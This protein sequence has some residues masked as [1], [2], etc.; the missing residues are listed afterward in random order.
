MSETAIAIAS[1]LALIIVNV[2]VGLRQPHV[3][4]KAVSA[5][6]GSQLTNDKGESLST[7][8]ENTI[9]NKFDTLS[10]TFDSA[11]QTIQT[12]PSIA[13][14]YQTILTFQQEQLRQ[15]DLEIN[16]FRKEI[17]AMKADV[18]SRANERKELK[19]TVEDL[20][21]LTKQQAADTQSQLDGMQKSQDRTNEELE[22]T[23]A[24]LAQAR[25]QLAAAEARIKHIEEERIAER[26]ASDEEKKKLVLELEAERAKVVQ[27]EARV[28]QLEAEIETL[29]S[30]PKG[31][32]GPLTPV[33]TDGGAA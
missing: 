6:V 13:D 10:R 33:T 32:T 4:K 15:R 5:E 12:I 27:L 30:A 17:A 21:K 2:I 23:K 19:Q 24:E 11:M 20:M 22:K 8:V 3:V 16:E 28:K 7:T 9:N 18:E 31:D 1:F 14:G 29:K 26:T 25:E